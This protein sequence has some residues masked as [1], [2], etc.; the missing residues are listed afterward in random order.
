MAGS[1]KI[2]ITIE[3]L[4][5]ICLYGC[6]SAAKPAAV[7]KQGVYAEET[8]GARESNKLSLIA[9]PWA[10]GETMRLKA[11][12]PQGDETGTMIYSAEQVTKAG[13]PDE[14]GW[15]T[16]SHNYISSSDQQQYAEVDAK[17]KDFEPELS[18]IVNLL[19]DFRAE[20][21]KK[22]IRL[23][24]TG[25]AER[26]AKDIDVNG[27]VY[28]SEQL[29]HFVRRLPLEKDYKV[30]LPIFTV[31]NGAVADCNIAVVGKEQVNTG[32][33][34]FDCYRVN[35]TMRS[36]D[37]KPLQHSLWISADEH[38]YLT[39]YIMDASI[40]LELVE[41]TVAD[42]DAPLIFKDAELGCTVAIPYRWQYYKHKAGPGVFVELLAPELKA[43][44]ALCVLAAPAD[45]NP[46][47][48]A[49][50]DATALKSLFTGYTV[51]GDEFKETSIGHL[52]AV[53]Y[54]ADFSEEANAAIKYP[55]PKEMVEY[56]TYITSGERVYFFVFRAEKDKF[57]GSKNEFDAIIQSLELKKTVKIQ[58]PNSV[59]TTK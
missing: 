31:V 32:A 26:I 58:E 1:V 21:G 45:S 23:E 46:A 28:D 43:K 9:A 40:K 22:R 48:V 42:K 34:T 53:Q 30:S 14:S 41:V 6:G 17:L 36:G 10:D 56:R 4:M 8:K 19:G 55:R 29:V 35:L 54:V 2:G 33:G 24:S 44:A 12:S 39:R 20:Y 7:Q 13:E 25:H 27:V 38:R 47:Y 49:R 52:K 18:H 11:T 59:I 51:R 15:R 50:H 3:V 37:A 57:D 5:V 16:I